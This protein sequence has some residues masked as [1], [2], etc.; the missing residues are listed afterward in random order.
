MSNPP[1]ALV[2]V[3]AVPALM[4]ITPLALS[5]CIATVGSNMDVSSGHCRYDSRHEYHGLNT[6]SERCGGILSFDVEFSR[7]WRRRTVLGYQ[8]SHWLAARLSD[9]VSFKFSSESTTSS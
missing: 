6:A 7:N 2:M 4:F 1:S 3:W 8:A 9:G 5:A